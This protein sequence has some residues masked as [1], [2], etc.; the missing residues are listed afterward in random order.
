MA[1]PV[2]RLVRLDSEHGH[3]AR[4]I[5]VGAAI[6][7]VFSLC[8]AGAE[9]PPRIQTA[10]PTDQVI[11]GEKLG[12]FYFAPRALNQQHEQ[13]V[14]K[15][16]TLE[17]QIDAGQISAAEARKQILA[18]RTD[19]ESVRKQLDEVKTFV[20]LA[21]MATDSEPT[22][23][24]LDKEKTLLIIADKVHLIGWD[25]PEV[26]CVLEKTVLFANKDSTEEQLRAIQ[27]IHHTGHAKTEQVGFS[28]EDI[29]ASEQR[30]LASPDGKK[31]DAPQL[32]A[33]KKNVEKT[34]RTDGVFREFQN[35]DIDIVEIAGLKHEQGNRQLIFEV[36]SLNG[37]G[38]AG[39]IWQRHANLTVYV[40]K[41]R[42]VGI[43]GGGSGLAVESVKSPLVARGDGTRSYQSEFWVKDH[44][45]PLTIESLPLRSVE[46]VQGPVSIVI[47]ADLDNSST[48]HQNDEQLQSF[49]PPKPLICRDVK[50]DFTARLVRSKL[51]LSEI[52]GRIDVTNEFGDTT[53]IVKQPLPAAAHRI[54]SQAGHIELQVEPTALEKS[55]PLLAATECGAVLASGALPK[56]D[57]VNIEGWPEGGSDRRGLMGLKTMPAAGADRFV[58]NLFDR[59]SKILQDE[60]RSPGIDLI[61]RGGRVHVVATE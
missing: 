2:D 18:L 54:L 55:P 19:L 24:S 22:T 35:K 61:S 27:L 36:K 26:K 57:D 17:S 15:V 40:P 20:P 45:G 29:A 49:E 39:G 60:D 52:S 37:G 3:I 9:E 51:Q 5:L 31:M 42:T 58:L 13:L 8:P 56:F 34:F 25:Q 48:R 59:I 7:M 32:E 53:L 30:F 41:C 28:A 6:L 16:H 1:P 14:D 43:L 10:A 11:V 21:G 12:G 46:N 44:T 38:R 50:G 23:F 4:T 47:T 33:W